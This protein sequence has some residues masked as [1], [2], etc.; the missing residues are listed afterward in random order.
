LTCA[1]EVE[2]AAVI[3]Q[4]H[5]RMEN[6]IADRNATQAE[7][8]AAHAQRVQALQQR[9]EAYRLA[10]SRE[11]VR[12]RTMVLARRLE[13]GFRQREAKYQRQIALHENTI[14][15]LLPEVHH[16]HNLRDPILFP[17]AAEMDPAVITAT[18]DG[19]IDADGEEEPEELMMIDESDD[20]GGHVSGVDSDH[21]D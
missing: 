21:D 18:N 15:D 16:L 1:A 14:V 6:A 13:N 3:Q 20:E 4:V 10:E 11:E 2:G 19:A 8:R 9:D 7:A 17:G 5:A 12:T